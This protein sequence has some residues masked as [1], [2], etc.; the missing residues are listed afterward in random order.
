MT[1]EDYC[2]DEFKK[3]REYYGTDKKGYYIYSYS[4]PDD[5][6]DTVVSACAFC[7]KKLDY[8]KLDKKTLVK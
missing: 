7:G 6:E 3:Y 5:S 2:C 1:E 4:N 8:K